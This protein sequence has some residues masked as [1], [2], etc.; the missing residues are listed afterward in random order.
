MLWIQVLTASG[1]LLQGIISHPRLSIRECRSEDILENGLVEGGGSLRPGYVPPHNFL[2]NIPDWTTDNE[3]QKNLLSLYEFYA[4][5][6]D[7][8]AIQRQSTKFNWFLR[9]D[10]VVSNFL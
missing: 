4:D 5:D 1:C 7:E 9:L 6:A 2:K 3:L 10:G 8:E